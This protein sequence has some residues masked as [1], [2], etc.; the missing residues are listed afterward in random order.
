[1]AGT[2]AVVAALLFLSF[3]VLA[4][5]KPFLHALRIG[6]AR[7]GQ[8]SR[9]LEHPPPL[10]E[11][12]DLSGVREPRR[13]TPLGSAGAVALEVDKTPASIEA[14]APEARTHGSSGV[15]ARAA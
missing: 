3:A 5:A 2:V 6:G 15:D 1:M 11:P 12:P 13:P 10:S 9:S 8:P 14:I 4:L 7:L